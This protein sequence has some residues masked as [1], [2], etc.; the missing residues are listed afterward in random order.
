MR[1]SF[2]VL[3]VPPTEPG[4]SWVWAGAPPLILI[5]NPRVCQL[6]W[7]S[8]PDQHRRW[9]LNRELKKT[10]Q[11]PGSSLQKFTG[12]GEQ[13]VQKPWGRCLFNMFEAFREPVCGG[14]WERGRERWCQRVLS[15]EVPKLQDVGEDFTLCTYCMLLIL[16]QSILWI[17]VETLLSTTNGRVLPP[18]C[19]SQLRRQSP[20]ISAVRTL[21]ELLADGQTG[22][23]F[24]ECRNGT[25]NFHSVSLP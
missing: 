17:Q 9:Q 13:P 3:L 10:R 6:S 2:C 20:G 23:S 8:R 11:E 24:L 19:Q 22:F 14:P 15:D 4:T 21:S 1:G 7:V 18:C 16:L 5:A 12:Q 25:Q